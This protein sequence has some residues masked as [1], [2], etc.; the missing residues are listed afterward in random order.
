M[1]PKLDRRG[2]M[3]VGSLFLGM[4][5]VKPSPESKA[6]LSGVL[7]QGTTLLN[8]GGEDYGE[9][10]QVKDFDPG[11]ASNISRSSGGLKQLLGFFQKRSL[12]DWFIQEAR[13][14]IREKLY[15]REE[16][17]LDPDLRSYKSFSLSAKLLLQERRELDKVELDLLKSEMYDKRHIALYDKVGYWLPHTKN[18]GL[19]R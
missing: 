2:F 15:V 9:A 8:T 1:H 16:R 11:T 13:L 4:L 10:V 5:G 7:S 19:W 6:R 17:G 3:G 14:N 18:T 12:P